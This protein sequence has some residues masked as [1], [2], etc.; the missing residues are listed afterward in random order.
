MFDYRCLQMWN[1]IAFKVVTANGKR[2]SM[3]LWP[4]DYDV[5]QK[6]NTRGIMLKQNQLKV[7]NT[8]ES[9]INTDERLWP[10]LL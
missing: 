2:F 3:S 4:D 1:H 5:D 10:V 7:D 9:V 6:Q 8:A